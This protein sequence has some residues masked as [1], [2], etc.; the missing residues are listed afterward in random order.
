MTT[1]FGVGQ[2]SLTAINR[3]QSYLHQGKTVNDQNLN[4]PK[5]TPSAIEI[6]D[7]HAEEYVVTTNYIKTA[8]QPFHLF[9]PAK[10][11]ADCGGHKLVMG[12]AGDG[13]SFE[14]T[15]SFNPMS[16]AVDDEGRN[17]LI[18]FF[19]EMANVTLTAEQRAGYLGVIESLPQGAHMAD[20]VRAAKLHEAATL[21]VSIETFDA[22]SP[23]L[24]AMS[25]TSQNSGEQNYF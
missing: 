6:L 20:F 14:G 4:A 7:V 13:M 18:D 12:R 23:L 1:T 25:K 16:A 15:S 9:D 19:C 22:L 24:V 17:W 5:S 3:V 11:G 10:S 8:G 2:K 21:G